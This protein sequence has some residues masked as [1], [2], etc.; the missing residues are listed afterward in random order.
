MKRKNFLSVLLK[1]TPYLFFAW[2]GNRLVFSL[3]TVPG[4]NFTEKIN[5]FFDLFI[6]AVTVNLLPS[7]EMTDLLGG[8]AISALIWYIMYDRKNTRKKL[9]LGSEHGSAAFGTQADIKP[10]LDYEN[11]DNNIILTGTE[12]LTMGVGEG[13]LDRNK[14]VIVFGGAGTGKTRNHL[15]PGLMQM[16]KKM[17]FITTDPKGQVLKACGNMLK[18]G[19]VCKKGDGTVIYQPYKIKVFNTVE[20]SESMHYNPFS[21]FQTETL[22]SDIDTFITMFQENTGEKE[23]KGDKFFP[24]AE[25]LLYK[26]C[27]G[28]IFTLFPEKDRN[29]NT[30]CEL[31][32]NL[33]AADVVPGEPV[34]YSKTEILFMAMEDWL[35]GKPTA[36]YKG[37]N[38]TKP[39]TEDEK[40][41]GKYALDNYKR[42]KQGAGKTMKGILISCSVRLGVF[43]SKAVKEIV[44]RDDL[45]LDK[46]GDELTAFFIIVDDSD[47]TYNFLAAIMY[48]QLF[49]L[50]FK[51]A[52]YMPDGKLKYHVRFYLDEF[53]NCGRIPDFE[54]KISVFR[55]RNIS[56]CIILQ[57][58][59]QLQSLYKDDSKT[60]M[61]NCDSTLFLGGSELSTLEYFSKMLGKETID[62]RN[63]SHSK[64]GAGSYTKSEQKTGRELMSPDELRLMDGRKCILFIR[65]VK[66]FFSMKFD[67]T[68]HKN[69]Y[70]LGNDKNGKMFDT[71]KYIET[72]IEKKI[73][74]IHVIEKDG[75]IRL[76]RFERKRK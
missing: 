66:P 76:I 47:T 71:K 65:G 58:L 48:A 22:T 54:R 37:L 27:I 42:F 70:R 41:I 44:S 31:I 52:Y 59:S 23:S 18:K 35:N 53:A 30:L 49:K 39:A 60:I 69:Y 40:E 4:D 10:F 64:G 57:A 43:D 26:A 20:W 19:R 33:T 15:L 46:I 34:K 67:L 45:E 32:T 17:S 13:V 56:C 3:R 6:E 21:Y 55:S 50:L 29:I 51:R 36:K 7:F 62:T 8:I 68:K 5:N 1:L 74:K 14:N 12:W 72:K 28:M 73:E 24:D 61:E 16:T 75:D 38:F 2:A 9:R 63:F 11:P 25:K